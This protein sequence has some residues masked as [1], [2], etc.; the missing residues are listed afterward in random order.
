M[1]GS[2]RRANGLA[3]T[4]R[5][6][7]APG[8][9]AGPS[10]AASLRSLAALHFAFKPRGKR[11]IH[12]PPTADEIRACHLARGRAA[13]RETQDPGVPGGERGPL[14]AAGAL[15]TVSNL[16]RSSQSSVPLADAQH[17]RR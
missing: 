14:G 8:P 1:T 13:A 10:N 12:R 4:S 15:L 7:D 3:T 5:K 16:D 2:R 11:R 6:P 9:G 17:P